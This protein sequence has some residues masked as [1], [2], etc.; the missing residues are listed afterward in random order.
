MTDSI[1]GIETELS[2][3][4]QRID[5]PESEQP[6][7][8][9]TEPSFVQQIP[10]VMPPVMPPSQAFVPM[11][12]RPRVVKRRPQSKMYKAKRAIRNIVNFS[13]ILLVLLLIAVLIYLTFVRYYLAGS[14]FMH[15]NKLVAAALLSPELS[16]GLST[17]ALAL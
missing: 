14:S 8:V 11:Q 3:S 6:G 10:P 17:L 13:I 1:S 4:Y 9:V 5:I 12:V 15:G 16:T 7:I 2:K